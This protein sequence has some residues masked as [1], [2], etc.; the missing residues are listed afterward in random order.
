MTLVVCVDKFMADLMAGLAP[1][2]NVANDRQPHKF[3]EQIRLP[4]PF[5]VTLAHWYG[6]EPEPMTIEDQN[7]HN[8]LVAESAALV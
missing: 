6:E 4:K 1:H 7:F 5:I 8:K 3:G 2:N